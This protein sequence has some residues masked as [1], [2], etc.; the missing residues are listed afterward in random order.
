M[1]A[2]KTHVDFLELTLPFSIL[3]KTIKPTQITCRSQTLL[4]NIFINE[5]HFNIITGN[6]TTDISDHL[7]QHVAIPGNWHTE[8]S[9]QD[10]CRR[11]YKNHNS[12][13]F[14]GDFNTINWINLSSDKNVDDAYDSFLDEIE[15][16]INKASK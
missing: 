6:T 16:I 14:K 12:D 10:I 5:L 9:S 15:K 2:T 4:D 3:P 11:N 8:I 13:K 7:T 1:T